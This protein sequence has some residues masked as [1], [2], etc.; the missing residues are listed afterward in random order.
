MKEVNTV[1]ITTKIM[2]KVLA[3]GEI[4]TAEASMK[5]TI[6]AVTGERIWGAI[7]KI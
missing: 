3:A 7:M 6:K 2:V 4:M 1:G 5:T